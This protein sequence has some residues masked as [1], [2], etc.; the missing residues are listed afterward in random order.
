MI[1]L[2]LGILTGFALAAWSGSHMGSSRLWNGC[3]SFSLTIPLPSGMVYLSR[4]P[5]ERGSASGYKRS[6]YVLYNGRVMR[7]ACGRFAPS[8]RGAV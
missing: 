8:V 6:Y 4:W 2:F 5:V 3:R 1:G 7:G